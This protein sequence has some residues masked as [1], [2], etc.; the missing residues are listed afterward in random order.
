MMILEAK[1]VCK[2]YFNKQALKGIDLTIESGKIVGLL[3]PNGSGKSTFLKL[4]AGLCKSTTGNIKI[5]NDQN[6]DLKQKNLLHIYL[7][8]I[9]Y[10]PG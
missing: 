10:T 1:G 7:I 3:G 8:V 2:K 9:I 6:W 5:C 4:L